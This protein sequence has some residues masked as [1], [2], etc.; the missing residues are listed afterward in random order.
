[1]TWVAHRRRPRSDVVEGWLLGDDQS[2][3]SCSVRTR[4]GGRVRRYGFGLGLGPGGNPRGARRCA[5]AQ[6]G[7]RGPAAWSEA[8]S[9]RGPQVCSTGSLA[10]GSVGRYAILVGNARRSR[11]GAAGQ[12]ER[13]TSRAGLSAPTVRRRVGGMPRVAEIADSA[14]ERARGHRR[15]Q[16]AVAGSPC[17]DRSALSARQ[18]I[19]LGEYPARQ[20]TSESGSGRQTSGTLAEF[21]YGRS[22]SGLGLPDVVAIGPRKVRTCFGRHDTNVASVV[23][24]VISDSE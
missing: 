7:R 17:C 4:V 1:M 11:S 18:L 8:L 10:T 3:A 24:F 20:A 13:P 23:F 19:A 16:L 2:D 15:R 6:A 9:D 22:D 14:V 21:G 5:A 12:V